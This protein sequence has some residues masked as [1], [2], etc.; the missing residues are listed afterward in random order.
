[1]RIR[2]WSSDVGSSELRIADVHVDPDVVGDEVLSLLPEALSRRARGRR[3]TIN[4]VRADARPVSVCFGDAKAA[5]R[6]LEGSVR[7]RRGPG[8]A[9]SIDDILGGIAAAPT[10]DHRVQA[11]L[12]ID[13]VPTAR[14]ISAIELAMISAET[15]AGRLR[16]A[17][18]LDADGRHRRRLSDVLPHDAPDKIGRAHV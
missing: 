14:S 16:T 3:I 5:I 10:F 4:L 1:M 13:A 12:P 11:P 18:W 2:D 15:L 6:Y 9:P 8:G 17:E 7:I